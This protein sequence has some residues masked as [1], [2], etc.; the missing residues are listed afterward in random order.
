MTRTL[1]DKELQA[2][3][4]QIMR[5]G[6]LAGQAMAKTLEALETSNQDEAGN[7]IVTDAVID[8]LRT[9]IEEHALHV[10]VLQQPLGRRDLRY[11]TSL[12]SITIDL[13]RIGDE[14]EGIAQNVLR[15]MP[16]RSDSMQSTQG[17]STSFAPGE[18]DTHSSDFANL[19]EMLNVGH[20]VRYLLQQTMTA[21][22]T[23]DAQTARSLW[24]K[25]PVVRQHCYSV[26]QDLMTLLE[27]E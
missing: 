16:F 6:A 9:A 27:G 15:M 21:F 24:E 5:L 11:L 19:R 20:E 26:R 12:P 22:V 23:R 18:G 2:L 8:D 1:L 14:A 17:Q 4:A 10:L 25:D 7:V 13:E 3:D